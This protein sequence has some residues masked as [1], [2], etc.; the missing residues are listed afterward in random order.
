MTLIKTTRTGQKVTVDKGW[1]CLDSKRFAHEITPIDPWTKKELDKKE[2]GNSYEYIAHRLIMTT[3]EGLKA[4][5]LIDAYKAEEKA[6][7]EKVEKEEFDAMVATGAA[8]RT[9][10]VTEQYGCD[11]MWACRFTEEEKTQY[12]DWFR[13][14][15]AYSLP[16]GG[17]VKVERQAVM[18]VIGSRQADVQFNGCAN[19]AWTITEGEWA[20]IIRLSQDIRAEKKQ[21]QEKYAEQE[22]AAL[23]KKIDTG[24][25]FRCE[26]WCHGDCGNYSSNPE[27]LFRR[28]LKQGLTEANFGITE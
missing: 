28:Q 20:E 23:Q 16:A 26:S 21:A 17:R 14:L 13:E 7:R 8:F 1:V 27:I 9:A 6:K 2:P 4:K 15:G 10:E 18:Q 22:T 25:C 3:E 24:Y 12:S 5:A 19:M 11:L